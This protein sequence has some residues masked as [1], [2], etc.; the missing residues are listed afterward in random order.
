MSHEEKKFKYVVGELSETVDA[1]TLQMSEDLV[2]N[3]INIVTYNIFKKYKNEMESDEA[4]EKIKNNTVHFMALVI[5]QLIEFGK[6]E[7]E[8]PFIDLI[9]EALQVK[10]EIV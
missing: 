2:E 4:L 1:K 5:I 7:N 6:G 10:V 8:G 9:K 3:A